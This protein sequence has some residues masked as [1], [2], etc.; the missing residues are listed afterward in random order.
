MLRR[1]CCDVTRWLR[2]LLLALALAAA[3]CASAQPAT[4]PPTTATKGPPTP[5]ST[6]GGNG[7]SAV[8]AARV[9]AKACLHTDRHQ[10]EVCTAYVA[11]ASYLARLPYYK[12]G[13]SADADLARTFRER[14]E[15]RYTGTARAMI[16]RQT[17]GWPG[18]SELDVFLPTIQIDSVSVSADLSHAAL[19]THESWLVRTESGKA[20]FEERDVAHVITLARVPGLVL[21]KWVV[22]AIR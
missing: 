15:S 14:L 7:P 4:S 11:N 9:S 17:A 21:H 12:F 2:R 13:H 16:E 18:P 22:T 6:V 3:G 8:A 19:T 10:Y 1:Y 5:P 20:L